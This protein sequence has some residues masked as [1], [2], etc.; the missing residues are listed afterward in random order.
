MQVMLDADL[1]ELYNVETKQIN[2][3]VKRN[4]DRFPDD[5]MFQ[6]SIN[7]FDTLRSQIV[8]LNTKDLRFQSGTS[9][10]EHGGRR[11]LPYAFTEQGVAMLSGVLR[12]E[13]AIKVSIQTIG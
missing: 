10:L 4:S 1:A 5:F 9:R 13:T 11:Y 3:A 2:R 12:S 8:T 6:I 7:E